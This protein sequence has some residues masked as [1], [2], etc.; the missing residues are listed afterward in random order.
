MLKY[1]FLTFCLLVLL[2]LQGN[3]QT[4]VKGTVLD[5]NGESLPGVTVL[6]TGT[7]NGTVTTGDGTFSFKTMTKKA[8]KLH[9]SFLGYQSFNYLYTPVSP[10]KKDIKIKMK[11]AST[12]LNQVQIVGDYDGQRKAMLEQKKATNIKNIVSSEQ[13]ED[14]PDMNAAEAMQRIPGVTLQREQGEGKYVQL[15]GTPPELTNFN[16]NGEQIP[17]PEGDIRTVG[18]DVISS[19]QIDFIEI[20]KVLTPD[21]DG[22]AIGGSVNIITK[23]ALSEIPELKISGSVG[24]SALRATPNSNLQFTYGK[25][26][27]KIGFHIN[28]SHYQNKS[29]SDNMEF[30][31]VKGPLWSDTVSNSDN[32]HM[33]YREFQLRQY[34]YTK[35]RTG[36]SSTLDYR[37]NKKHSLYLRGMYNNYID[38]QQRYRNIFN[39]EDAITFNSYLYGSIQHDVKSRTKA[40]VLNSLNFGGEDILG[41]FTIDYE[42]AYATASEDTPD[43]LEASFTNPGQAITVVIDNSDLQFPRPSIPDDDH[44]AIATNYEEYE[45]DNLMLRESYTDD[46]T[47][48]AKLNIKKKYAFSSSNEGYVKLG[49]K[50]RLRDKSRDVTTKNYANYKSTSRLYPPQDG[51]DELTLPSVSAD[52]YNDNLLGHGYVMEYMP[53]AEKILDFYNF[54]QHLFIFGDK[55]STESRKESYNMDYEANENVFAAYAMVQHEFKNF[56]ILGGARFEKTM[57]DYKGY[58]IEEDSTYYIDTIR[59]NESKNEKSFLLPQMQVKYKFSDNFNVRAAC[60]YTFTRPNFKDVIPQYEEDHDDIEFGNPDI[61]YPYSMNIDLMA[62][63]YLSNNG[64]ISGGLFYKNIDNF[65]VYYKVN[66]FLDEYGYG[67]S[68]KEFTIPF[69]GLEAMVYGAEMQAQYKFTKLPSFLSNIGIYCNYTFTESKGKIFK[70]SKAAYTD[71]VISSNDYDFETVLKTED[72][73]EITL[74]GQAKHNANLA[75]FY[76]SKKVFARLAFNYQDDFL[77]SLG[78]DADLD[79]YYAASK[80]LDFTANYKLNKFTSISLDLVNLTDEPLI[81]YLGSKDYVKKQEYYSWSGRIGIKLNL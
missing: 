57:F 69:N 15:R 11:I 32:Y 28:A 14:F 12:Q 29:G 44:Y 73:E 62:E 60:T 64:I 3:S 26:H 33:Q 1:I 77:V 55:G 39:L 74:P 68:P 23:K 16:I 6:E 17:S 21:M 79:E 67:G 22:D 56:L 27:N 8:F 9:F 52:L 65:I 37:F 40:Q 71:L 54:N 75:L 63:K 13:I 49:C 43:R 31:Y 72:T 5:E 41:A 51:G 80:H 81:T 24:Y 35:T 2:A 66:A 76:E 61:E 19:D 30:D 20:T 34:E 4:E 70:R 58:I 59:P 38:D 36:L 50:V 48:T 10:P 42:L 47:K 25:R 46:I 45:F 53:S 18:M 7:S 78:N